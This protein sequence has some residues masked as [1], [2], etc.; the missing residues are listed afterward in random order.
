MLSNINLILHL[1]T[2]DLFPLIS[3][4]QRKVLFSAKMPKTNTLQNGIL[5][6]TDVLTNVGGAYN[7]ADSIFTAPVEGYYVFVWS[8]SQ[9]STKY[10]ESSITK[11]GARIAS[12]S[13]Y[14]AR[15]SG[16]STSETVALH[17]VHGDKIW[18]KLFKG[19]KPV[20][21]GGV[22]EDVNVFTGFLL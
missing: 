3:D 14:A 7:P 18:I 5:R 4:I 16:D 22:F 9:Y 13:V 1:N 8:T 19:S 21:D 17:L 15:G 2:F 10:T 11:N 6:Y 20:V 12:Q